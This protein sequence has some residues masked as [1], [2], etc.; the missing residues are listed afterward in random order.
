MLDVAE[1]M[2]AVSAMQPNLRKT[3]FPPHDFHTQQFWYDANVTSHK[4]PQV[5]PAVLY[6]GELVAY[7]KGMEIFL[8]EDYKKR[9]IPNWDTFQAMHFSPHHVFRLSADHFNAIPTGLS[10]PPLDFSGRKRRLAGKDKLT[11][12][13]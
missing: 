8:V 12:D 1:R 10:L 13:K 6:N 11:A 3:K 5:A 4:E 2:E 7:V 9:S